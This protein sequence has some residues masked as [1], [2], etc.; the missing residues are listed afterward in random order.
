MTRRTIPRLIYVTESVD[1]LSL[2]LKVLGHTRQVGV[3][4]ILHRLDFLLLRFIMFA[5]HF[6][7]NNLSHLLLH[8]RI[9]AVVQRS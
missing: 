7:Q 1:R 5:Q 8:F 9:D 2:N 3:I 4:T 6:L